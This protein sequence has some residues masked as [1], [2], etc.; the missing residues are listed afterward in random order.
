MQSAHTAWKRD[1]GL[2][3]TVESWNAARLVA[4]S[5]RK[6]GEKLA[7]G[8]SGAHPSYLITREANSLTFKTVFLSVTSV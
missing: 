2:R 8:D 5:L 3:N 4:L 1:G 7:P 6:P